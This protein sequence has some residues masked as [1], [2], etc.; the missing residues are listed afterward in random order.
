MFNPSRPVVNVPM[1]KAR[2]V[3]K[4]VCQ[5]T[6]SIDLFWTQLPMGTSQGVRVKRVGSFAYRTRATQITR[7]LPRKYNEGTRSI[8]R[9]AV[10]LKSI[11]NNK[12]STVRDIDADS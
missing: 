10:E 6:S 7:Y 3:A 1:H 9:D 2:Q 11:G 8:A 4:N 5:Q 12:L